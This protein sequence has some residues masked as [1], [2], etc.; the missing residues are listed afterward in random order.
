MQIELG[1]IGQL[2]FGVMSQ[3]S[4]SFKMMVMCFLRRIAHEAYRNSCVYPCTVKFGGDGVTVW[5]AMSYRGTG[6]LTF[7]KDNLNKDDYLHILRNSAIPSAHLRGYED[8]IIFLDHGAPMP[9][10]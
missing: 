3:D 7:L 9:E 4:L 10:S 1:L 8:N 6:F 5:G 2:C